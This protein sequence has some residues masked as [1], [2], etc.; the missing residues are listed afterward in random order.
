MRNRIVLEKF[1]CK[2]MSVD[3]ENDVVW[4]D[5]I[6]ENDENNGQSDHFIRFYDGI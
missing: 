5:E 2:W 1:L 4:N 3:V 6:D